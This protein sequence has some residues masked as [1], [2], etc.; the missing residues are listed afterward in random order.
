MA[1]PSFGSWLASWFGSWFGASSAAPAPTTI[2]CEGLCCCRCHKCKGHGYYVEGEVTFGTYVGTWF[3][4]GTTFDYHA[5]DVTTS[6]VGQILSG[7]TITINAFPFNPR[8][9]GSEGGT[10]VCN[11]DSPAF[12]PVAIIDP[13]LGP[14]NY[15]AFVSL[16]DYETLGISAVFADPPFGAADGANYHVDTVDCVGS[17]MDVSLVPCAASGG[18]AVVS[19]CPT[20]F[21]DNGTIGGSVWAPQFDSI[22]I[23][24]TGDYFQCGENADGT[25]Y[26]TVEGMRAGG[27]PPQGKPCSEKIADMVRAKAPNVRVN[28]RKPLPLAHPDRCLHLGKRTE[29]RAGCNGW[30]CRHDCEKGL[31]AVPGLFCQTCE[32]Y[33]ADPDYADEGVRSWLS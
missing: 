2:D 16:T 10:G 5:G 20:P 17:G 18:A 26:E 31:A 6:I 3:T 27:S 33:E 25:P 15:N 32:S 28:L 4:N 29:L 24:W 22:T 14:I 19:T 23:T 7:Q 30:K 11:F 21:S 13:F 9:Y 8:K 1:A 12:G